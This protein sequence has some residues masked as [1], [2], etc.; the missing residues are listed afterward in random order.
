M[1]PIHF[2]IWTSLNYTKE[3]H[4]MMYSVG[5]LHRIDPKL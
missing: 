5:C 3:E 4:S 1:F 2:I